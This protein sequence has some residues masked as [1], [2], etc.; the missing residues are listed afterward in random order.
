[1][2]PEEQNELGMQRYYT[3]VSYLVVLV[4]ATAAAGLLLAGCTAVLFAYPW[5]LLAVPVVVIG[6]WL[7]GMALRGV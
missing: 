2:T 5:T 7:T 4:G 1:M 6:F 3:L